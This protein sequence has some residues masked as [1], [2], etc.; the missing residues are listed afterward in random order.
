[1]LRLPARTQGPKPLPFLQNRSKMTSPLSFEIKPIG[2]ISSALLTHNISTFAEA[3]KFISQ[4]PYER[5]G[6]K[7]DFICKPSLPAKPL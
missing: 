3:A 6:N 2:L 5:N 4:F 7:A 1:M